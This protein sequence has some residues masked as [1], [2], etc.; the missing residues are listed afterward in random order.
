MPEWISHLLTAYIAI[1]ILGIKNRKGVYIG[2]LLPDLFK[3]YIALLGILGIIDYAYLN[4]LA[5]FH[6]V[7]GAL[8]AGLFISS[9]FAEWRRAYALI[10]LGLL[11]HFTADIL[12]YPWGIDTWI[13][14]PLWIGD[15]GTGVLWPDSIRPL[16]IL[17]SISSVFYLKN[18]LR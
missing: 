15:L 13:L 9:F 6:T 10:L 4:P 8:L 3:V 7:F 17:L 11:L 5:P 12:L 18:R 1:S 14:Y 2:V 16:V